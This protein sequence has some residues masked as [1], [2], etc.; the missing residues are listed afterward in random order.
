MLHRNVSILFSACALMVLLFATGCKD[1]PKPQP[2]DAEVDM[3]PQCIA[4]GDGQTVCQELFGE[5]FFCSA[6]NQC[7]ELAACETA[8]CCAP[9][10]MGDAYCAEE[11]GPGSTCLAEEA[12]GRCTA[13]AC[14]GCTAD[15]AGHSCCYDALGSSWFCG[16]EGLCVESPPCAEDDCCVPGIAGDRACQMAYG[17]QSACLN[18]GEGGLCSEPMIPPCAGCRDTDEDH[19]C[20]ADDFGP[21]WFCG[22]EGICRQTSGCE[23][24]ECCVPGASG[25]AYCMNAFGDGSGCTIVS[26]DGRCQ[27]PNAPE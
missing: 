16:G 6:D 11:F 22:V 23:S 26:G 12:Q 25:N 8:D 21:A 18:V 4:D 24:A 2:V 10:D 19:Q 9:G 27:S 13:R 14:E 7:E 15:N 3:G 20:C 1:D 5:R 17:P